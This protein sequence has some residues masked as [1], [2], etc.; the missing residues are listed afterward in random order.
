[1]VAAS[2]LE[3]SATEMLRPSLGGRQCPSLTGWCDVDGVTVPVTL[4]PPLTKNE[5]TS[6]ALISPWAPPPSSQW[7]GIS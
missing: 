6:T 2:I 5:T 1:M 7:N 4:E 3:V